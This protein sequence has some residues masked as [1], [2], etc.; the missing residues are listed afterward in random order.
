MLFRSRVHVMIILM[1][2]MGQAGTILRQV[3]LIE[4][5]I[6][7]TDTPRLHLFLEEMTFVGPQA[8]L[9]LGVHT[10]VVSAQEELVA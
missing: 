5:V 1:V 4:E 8:L 10:E 6:L 2:D 7:V 3:I 9:R